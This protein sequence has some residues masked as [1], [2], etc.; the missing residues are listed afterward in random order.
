MLIPASNRRSYLWLIH[1]HTMPKYTC[2][3]RLYDEIIGSSDL[4]QA[5]LRLQQCERLLASRVVSTLKWRC[6]HTRNT[7]T[8]LA[9]SRRTDGRTGARSIAIDR[10]EAVLQDTAFV[11]GVAH[12]PI[13]FTSTDHR[14]IR[15]ARKHRGLNN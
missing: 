8:G 10:W 2:V 12:V 7:H 6:A 13:A 3:W 15:I 5:A 4:R 14:R 11:G 1:I 9:V